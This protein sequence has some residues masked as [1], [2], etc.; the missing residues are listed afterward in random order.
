MQYKNYDTIETNG[1]IFSVYY[2][3]DKKLIWAYTYV[4]GNLIEKYGLDKNSAYTALEIAIYQELNFR[5]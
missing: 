5:L 2:R 1:G 4:N 3:N